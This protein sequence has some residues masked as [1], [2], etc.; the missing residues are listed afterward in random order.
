MR[1]GV[2]NDK[3]KQT[4]EKYRKSGEIEDGKMYTNGGRLFSVVT[5]GKNVIEATPE[6]LLHTFG[7]DRFHLVKSTFSG[8]HYTDP[9]MIGKGLENGLFCLVREPCIG[10]RNQLL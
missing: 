2:A 3:A 9:R 8:I 5:S 6:Q 4:I 1:N 10:P 7:P